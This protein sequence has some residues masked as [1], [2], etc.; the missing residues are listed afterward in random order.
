MA[1]QALPRLIMYC[2]GLLWLDTALSW[3]VMAYHRKWCHGLPWL[4]MAC[5]GLSSVILLPPY[6]PLITVYN[7]LTPTPL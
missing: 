4:V 1:C 6:N 5:H 2:H 3:L 7:G